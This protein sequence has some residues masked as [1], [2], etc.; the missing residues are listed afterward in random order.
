M[1]YRNQRARRVQPLSAEL[2]LDQ[3]KKLGVHAHLDPH[4]ARKWV[5]GGGT[6]DPPEDRRLDRL[7][8]SVFLFD[9][10]ITCK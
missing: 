8:S 9:V 6:E 3:A 1:Y 4:T 10:C 7:S 2:T 5:G